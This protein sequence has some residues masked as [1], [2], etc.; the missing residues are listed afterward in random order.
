MRNLLM[1]A[2]LTWGLTGCGGFQYVT[3]TYGN[4]PVENVA[5]NDSEYRIFHRADLKK[6]M[7]TTT[8]GRAFTSGLTFQAYDPSRGDG[9]KI[10]C[11]TYLK[12]KG[13]GECQAIRGEEVMNGQVEFNYTC[14]PVSLGVQPVTGS[15]KK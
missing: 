10:A 12:D 1:I 13:F 11:E 4:V 14:Q 2:T 8:I 3:K 9:M 6:M 15:I 5:A 7:V